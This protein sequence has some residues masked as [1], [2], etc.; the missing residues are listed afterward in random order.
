MNLVFF[1]HSN[2]DLGN[3]YLFVLSTVGMAIPRRISLLEESRNRGMAKYH[4]SWI[5]ESK[6]Y[7]SGSR[8]ISRNENE[9]LNLLFFFQKVC[10]LPIFNSNSIISSINYFLQLNLLKGTGLYEG[11]EENLFFCFVFFARAQKKS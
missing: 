11:L 2:S 7:S 1:C 6:I 10:L 4:S 3:V 8:G 9:N 5:E